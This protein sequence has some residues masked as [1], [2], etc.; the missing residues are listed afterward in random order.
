MPC[1]SLFITPILSYLYNSHKQSVHS[2]SSYAD[3]GL[4]L[5][6]I[7]EIWVQGEPRLGVGQCPA[8]Y[9]DCLARDE[10]AGIGGQ[11]QEQATYIPG[12]SHTATGKVAY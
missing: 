4:L 2:S 11:I 9:E 8:I 3:V 5:E 12:M 1:T 6:Q 10:L 7:L